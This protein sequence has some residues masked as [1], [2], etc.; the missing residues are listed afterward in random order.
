MGEKQA[1]LTCE[2]DEDHCDKMP[3]AGLWSLMDSGGL[4]SLMDSGG[5]WSH[6]QTNCSQYIRISTGQSRYLTGGTRPADLVNE[7]C[8]S[9]RGSQ[10]QNLVVMPPHHSRKCEP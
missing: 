8:A 10:S 6:L 1:E 3:A 9:F 5:L 2:E 4:W 7:S